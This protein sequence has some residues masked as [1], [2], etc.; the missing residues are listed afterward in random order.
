MAPEFD[1]D[2]M[3]PTNYEARGMYFLSF[4][5]EFR[6]EVTEKVTE[7]DV[8]QATAAKS[9]NSLSRKQQQQQQ[10]ETTMRRERTS[11]GS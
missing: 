3:N 5:A 1:D 10:H 11:G 4:E 9:S 6:L 8:K 7:I 2:N